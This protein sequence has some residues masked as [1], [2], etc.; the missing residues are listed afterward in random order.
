[1]AASA[2]SSAFRRLAA[3]LAARPAWRDL[4]LGALLLLLCGILPVLTALVLSPAPSPLAFNATQPP[5]GVRLEQMYG[6]ERN[7]DGPFVWTK[8][9]AAIVVDLPGEG[10]YEVSFVVQDS[11]LAPAPRTLAVALDGMPAGSLPLSA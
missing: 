7:A 9:Q 10:P 3:P 2:S 5:A 11:P 8:P 1:M 4:G 6:G